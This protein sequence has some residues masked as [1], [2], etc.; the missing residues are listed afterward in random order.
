MKII[1]ILLLF[2]SFN[3]YQI[4]EYISQN[5]KNG[6]AYDDFRIKFNSREEYFRVDY[7]E[8]YDV[9][10]QRYQYLTDEELRLI[11]VSDF[12]ILSMSL[13]MVLYPQKK[14]WIDDSV[15]R[16]N[17]TVWYIRLDNSKTYFGNVDADIKIIYSDIIFYE[18][19]MK[20]CMDKYF[21]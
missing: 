16:H 4:F 21:K 14:N 9:F 1:I 5:Y 15:P 12:D 10:R 17:Q 18:Q 7:I 6:E 13:N 11:G 3:S 19:V 8:R 2:F 20:Y